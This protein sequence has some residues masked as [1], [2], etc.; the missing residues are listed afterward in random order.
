[1]FKVA[2]AVPLTGEISY[3]EV[4][5]RSRE[6]SGIYVPKL[7]LRRMIRHAITNY[8]FHEP[9][10]GFV[11]HNR[12]S[13]L[14]LQD[15]LISAWV[16]FICADMSVSVAKVVDAMIK[17]QGSEEPDETAVNLAFDQKLKWFDFIRQDPVMSVRYNKAMQATASGEGFSFSHTVN[18]YPWGDLGEATVVDVSQFATSYRPSHQLSSN[19]W[20]ATRVMYP[21]LSPRPIPSSASSSRTCPR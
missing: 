15:E 8:I 3:D 9:R 20:V 2:E 5:E 10:K 12:T 17:W 1:M 21:W 19:R 16:G 6:L 18:G 13:R 7:N 14:L 11:A 4:A